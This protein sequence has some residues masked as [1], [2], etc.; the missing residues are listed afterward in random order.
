[1]KV[2]EVDGCAVWKA[3]CEVDKGWLRGHVTNKHTNS[4]EQS[5]S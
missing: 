3:D 4:M 5:P 1:M 2:V